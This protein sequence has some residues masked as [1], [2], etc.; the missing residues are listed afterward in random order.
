MFFSSL[1]ILALKLRISGLL[2]F[3]SEAFLLS[4][5]EFQGASVAIDKFNVLK[6]HFF[7]QSFFLTPSF[8]HI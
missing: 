3:E 2:I 8:K 7:A 1:L 4:Q 6:V 5:Y